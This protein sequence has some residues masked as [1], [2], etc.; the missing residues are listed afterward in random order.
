[1]FTDYPNISEH[2]FTFNIDVLSG[3]PDGTL[4]DDKIGHTVLP[5]MFV[6]RLTNVI[7]RGKGSLT[8]GFGNLMT[9]RC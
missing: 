1:M 6:I 4:A 2:I 9:D 5:S 3:D 7:C 8:Y